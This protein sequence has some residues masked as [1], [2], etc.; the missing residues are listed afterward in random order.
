MAL[1]QSYG[2]VEGIIKNVLMSNGATQQDPN[3]RFYIDGQMINVDLAR[4]IAEAI[5]LF[6]V[7]QNGLNCTAKYTDDT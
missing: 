7:Y 1:V 6:E 3:G 5:Y 2:N 4:A